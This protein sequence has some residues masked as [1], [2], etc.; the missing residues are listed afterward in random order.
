MENSTPLIAL[1]DV[2]VRY[3]AG[4]EALKKVNLSVGKG[5]FVFVVGSSGSGKSTLIKTL[6]GE[7]PVTSGSI[8]VSGKQLNKLKRKELP[9]YRRMLGVVFQEFR[10]LEDRN[11]YENVALAQRV[12]GVSNERIKKNVSIMLDMVGLNDKSRDYPQELSGGEQQRVAIARAM[13]NRPGI[14]LADEPT[15]NLDPNNSWEIMTLLE[16]MNKLGTTV[17]VVTHNN[18]IVDRM[19]KRVVTLHQGNLISDEAQ[20]GYVQ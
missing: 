7:V 1:E 19:K 9:Y 10:L 12:I 11:V 15:G 16:E 5:E 3:T 13:V 8:R 14:L 18:E 20:G 17:I 6:L 4:T 2:V